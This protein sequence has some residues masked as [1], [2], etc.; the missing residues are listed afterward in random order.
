MVSALYPLTLATLPELLQKNTLGLLLLALL[1]QQAQAISRSVNAKRIVSLICIFILILLTHYGSTAA[2]LLYIS[3]FLLSQWIHKRS[4]WTLWLGFGLLLSSLSSLLAF[5]LFDIQRFERVMSYAIRMGEYSILGSLFSPENP[6]FLSSIGM[7][8][9]PIGFVALLYYG[10]R[11]S[12]ASLSQE[13]S[14]FWLCNILFCYLLLL[15]VYEPALLQR[16]VIFLA[17]PLFFVIAF[18]LQYTLKSLFWKRSLAGLALLGTT[19][20]ATGEITSLI[21]LNKDKEVIYH[22]L[23]VM[24]DAVG[25]SNNDLILTRNGAEHISNWFLETKSS[26]ITSFT[27]KDFERYDR[28]FLLNPT[29]GGST[30]PSGTQEDIQKYQYMMSNISEPAEAQIAYESDHIKLLQL[31]NPPKEWKFDKE[32][33]WTS[34]TQ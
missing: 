10:Y 18:T 14:V 3:A 2:A 4:K 8:V 29:E 19:V 5:Y 23:L 25:F 7:L 1:I 26:L 17:L 22:D 9:V 30:A 15:P 28:I 21:L 27:L 34:Y 24:K 6:D 12:N 32:G 16:F 33:N 31:P 13:T 20:F 11:K